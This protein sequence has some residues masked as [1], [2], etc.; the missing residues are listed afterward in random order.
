MRWSLIAGTRTTS[1]NAEAVSGLVTFIF[2][3]F[4]GSLK[5]LRAVFTETC[6]ENP[7][8]ILGT[9]TGEKILESVSANSEAFPPDVIWVSA[10]P[11]NRSEAGFVIKIT[12]VMPPV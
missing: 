7:I 3:A 9:P 6:P 5:D 11:M 1:T 4:L 2:D 10:M 8:T 12:V